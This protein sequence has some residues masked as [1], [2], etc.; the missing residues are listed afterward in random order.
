[1]KSSIKGKV[2]HIIRYKAI[3]T[4]L[5]ELEAKS[6]LSKVVSSNKTTESLIEFYNSSFIT[7]KDLLQFVNDEVKPKKKKKI[8]KQ[9]NYATFFLKEDDFILNPSLRIYSPVNRIFNGL[10][11]SRLNNSV[12]PDLRTTP[13]TNR[14]KNT[15]A[16]SVF[17][18][19]N[20]KKD[21]NEEDYFKSRAQLAKSSLN[22]AF[23]ETPQLIQKTNSSENKNIQNDKSTPEFIKYK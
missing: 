11:N 21:H 22:S 15:I 5:T 18:E 8:L 9:V 12:S 4:G 13:R 3:K 23:K 20:I 16:E 1:M 7:N 2:L 10:E 19:V 17:T 6:I 14:L